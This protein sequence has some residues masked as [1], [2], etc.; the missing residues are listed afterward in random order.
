MRKLLNTLYVTTP[1]AWLARDGECVVVKIDGEEKLKIPLINLENIITFSYAGA[2][3]ALMYAC[4]KYGIGL[5]FL[6]ENGHF[7]AR[8][9][10]K[11]NG[12]VLVR[13][14]QY[15]F[16]DDGK[17]SLKLASSIV[18]AKISNSR[19]VLERFLRDYPESPDCTRVKEASNILN[20]AK[21]EAVNARDA[22]TLRG[23][24]GN[25][26]RVYFSVFNALILRPDF[27][28]AGRNR[29]PPK[30]K[31][32]ALLSFAY[33]VLANDIQSALESAGIDSYVGFY[34]TDR[35]G[36]ASLA[37]D[38]MEEFR[39]YL[40]DRFVLSLIN[41]N[42]ISPEDFIDNG[43][44]GTVLTPDAKKIFL[45]N[46]QKRKRD[47]IV[48]PFLGEKVCIGLLGYV[49]AMMMS[50]YLRGELDGYPVFLI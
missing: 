22:D 48:H 21:I 29:R 20:Y 15:R 34:H 26:S 14:R 31:V 33:T 18:A 32:N 36:R 9:S 10:G 44:G 1:N 7:L 40:G 13:R 16:A 6:S 2:S 50:K 38:I 39:A 37:L 28:F 30:D 3:P 27:E 8:S 4:A 47:E 19:K 12:N 41:R 23:T 46:W 24:E 45:S 43:D 49:Q 11:T 5:S 25:A 35:P 42:M 17:I